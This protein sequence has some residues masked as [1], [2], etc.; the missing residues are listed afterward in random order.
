VG[1]RIEE[2]VTL[3][4]LART[5]ATLGERKRALE[6]AESAIQIN[7][8]VRGSVADPESRATYLA[9]V[10]GQYEFMTSLLMELSGSEPDSHYAERALENAERGHARGLLDLL[11]E[12]RVDIREGVDRSILAQ[13]KDLRAKLTNSTGERARLLSSGATGPQFARLDREISETARQLSDTQ[14]EIRRQSPRY[15]AIPDAPLISTSAIQHQLLDGDTA[16][17]E[18]NLGDDRSYMWLVTSDRA[19]AFRLPARREIERLARNAYRALS[20]GLVDD[21]A[22]AELSHIILEPLVGVLTKPR[23]AI[24]ADGALL[25]IPFG[26]LPMPGKRAEMLVNRIEIVYLPSAATVAILRSAAVARPTASK[27][28]AI[29]AD[30]VFHSDDPRLANPVRGVS[31]VDPG[32]PSFDRLPASRKEAAAIASLILGAD[33]RMGFDATRQ[34]LLEPG[35]DQYRILHLA[36]HSLLNSRHPEQSGVAFTLVDRMGRPVDGFLPLHEVVR[37]K[38]GADLVVLS[39][40]QTALGKEVLG[41]GLVGLA[42]GFMLAGAPRVVASLWQVSDQGTAEFMRHFYSAMVKENLTASAALRAAQLQMRKQSRW[43]RPYYW[44]GF[45][46]QGDWR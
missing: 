29:V 45:M 10:R 17:L 23:L 44:A 16:L 20:Q 25:Y 19:A 1:T 24:V 21:P 6:L 8:A 43:A 38:L 31:L 30:P 37:L 41:E 34:F 7:E 46:L 26:A 35:L 36:T 42:R 2:A 3:S 11:E 4:N 39:A 15:A 5:S 32:M 22:P 27:A 28:A 13:E 12:A 9:A 18:Y 40:C 33:V 14:A